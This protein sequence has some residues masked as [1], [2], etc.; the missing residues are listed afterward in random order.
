MRIALFA[1]E[2]LHSIAVGGIATHVTELAAGLKRRG[3]EVH[4]FTR[5]VAGQPTYERIDQVHYHRC[6][7]ELHPD[8]VTEMNNMGNSFTYA[9]ERLKRFWVN[10]SILYMDTIGFV[11]KGWFNAR[12]TA[13]QELCADR[14]FHRIWS[15][16]QPALQRPVGP[17]SIG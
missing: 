14:S 15:L 2:T 7:L 3:N 12:T 17:N 6:P 13:T 5:Q 10:H 1:W 11:R 9:L 8:F 16:W 4:V